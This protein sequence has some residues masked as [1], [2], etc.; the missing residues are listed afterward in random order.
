MAELVGFNV[1][2]ELTEHQVAYL[3][4]MWGQ[5]ADLAKDSMHTPGAG[6]EECVSV[7]NSYVRIAQG[8]DPDDE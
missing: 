5:F 2:D 6:C 8:K 1:P 3:F 7:F 4:G